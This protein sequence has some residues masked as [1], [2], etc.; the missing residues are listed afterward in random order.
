MKEKTRAGI[1]AGI[2]V[3]CTLLIHDLMVRGI[4]LGSLSDIL[5]RR[6]LFVFAFTFVVAAVNVFYEEVSR[7]FGP[8]K[9][10]WSSGLLLA[11]IV[12]LGGV[13]K[14]MSLSRTTQP[15]SE[16]YGEWLSQWWIILIA[17]SLGALGGH[18]GNK[19]M[20]KWRISWEKKSSALD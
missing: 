17:L 9:Y 20:R 11:A 8:F 12:E 4:S 5:I 6:C 7:T 15:A 3:V 1:V 10:A 2:I 16:V 14:I 13:W 19:V 18:L